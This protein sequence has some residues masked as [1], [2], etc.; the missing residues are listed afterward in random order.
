MVNKLD[1]LAPVRLLIDED[2]LR[3]IKEW[4]HLICSLDEVRIHYG[5]S[6]PLGYSARTALL[7]GLEDLGE[8]T[9]DTLSPYEYKGAPLTLGVAM[10]RWFREKLSKRSKELNIPRAALIRLALH[11]G[12]P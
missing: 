1:K 2:L 5:D 10:P 7:V 11:R 6:P 3:R 12:L 9:P 4:G 8:E